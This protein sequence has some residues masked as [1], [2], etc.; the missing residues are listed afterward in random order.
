MINA[1]EITRRVKTQLF[2][3][4][5][6]KN[7]DYTVSRGEYINKDYELAPWVGIYRGAIEYDPATLGD[8]LNS[9]RANMKLRLV[10][11]EASLESG[12]DAEEKLEQAVQDVLDVMMADKEWAGKGA[13]MTVGISVEY[14]YNETKSESIYFQSAMLTLE[15][16]VR[17]S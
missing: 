16:E 12:E 4:L 3:G 1:S 13:S 8:G 9:W 11:Q 10:V 14:S 17:T 15:A 2:N 5:K 6:V 7:K